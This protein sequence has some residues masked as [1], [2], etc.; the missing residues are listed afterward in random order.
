MNLTLIKVERNAPGA[1]KY[2]GRVIDGDKP[3]LLLNPYE[4]DG[5]QGSH[6]LPVA[7]IVHAWKIGMNSDGT[8]VFANYTIPSC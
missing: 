8:L 5:P 1:G 2:Y 6:A 4:S 3:C 7:L